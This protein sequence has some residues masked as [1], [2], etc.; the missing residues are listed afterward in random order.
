MYLFSDEEADASRDQREERRQPEHEPRPKLL[1]YEA[2]GLPYQY[3]S[4]QNNGA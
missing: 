2:A 3:S 4:R 1:Q